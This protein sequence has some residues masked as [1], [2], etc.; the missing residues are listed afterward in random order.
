MVVVWSHDQIKS[1]IKLLFDFLQ[2]TFQDITSHKRVLDTVKERA[3]AQL[4][5]SPKN[6]EI[7]DTVK[8]LEARHESLANTTK[9]SIENLEWL[10]DNMNSHQELCCSHAEWQKDM[11][12]KLHSYTG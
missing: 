4:Q 11:W 5:L 10:T 3:E 6:K 1:I 2:T 8:E 9:K 12:E 7:T